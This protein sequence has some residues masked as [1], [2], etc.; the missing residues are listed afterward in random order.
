MKMHSNAERI[1]YQIYPK[2]FMDSNHDGIGDLNGIT[3]RLDYLQSLGVNTL[4]LNPIFV[5]PQVDN[6]YDVSNYFRIEPTLGTMADFEKLVTSVH[7]R[8]MELILDLVLNHTSDQHPWFKD[9]VSDPQSIYRNY[10]LWD[11]GRAG[12]VP[13]NWASFFGGSVWEKDPAGTDEYYFHLFDKAMPDLNWKNPEVR[14]AMV[15]IA[16][17]WLQRGVDGFRL[18]AFIHIAKADF[19][20]DVFTA[21]SQQP[22]IADEYYANLPQVQE[23]LAE[24]V[25][26]LKEIKADV[27]ILG[28]ASSADI[29]L[30]ESYTDPKRDLCDSVVSFRYFQD[31]PEPQL[32]DQLPAAGQPHKLDLAQ[33]KR[34]MV[35]WQAVLQ[36]WSLPTLYWSNHDLPRIL[37]KLQIEPSMQTDAAK[38]LAV[39]MYLQRGIPC[40]YYGEE[41]GMTAGQLTDPADFNDELA[42]SFVAT[43][44]SHGF[45]RESLLESLSVSHK[46]GARSVMQWTDGVFAGFSSQTPWLN[47][48]GNGNSVL[49]EKRD[50]DSVLNFYGQVLALRQKKLFT[51]GRIVFEVND[52]DL[53]GYTR[54]WEKQQAYIMCNLTDHEKKIKLTEEQCASR[55]KL[56]NRAQF[57]RTANKLTLGAYGVLVLE[58]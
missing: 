3:Q 56:K 34:T 30:V 25:H 4:W 26:A 44:T 58:G 37:D 41:L 35:S 18:D 42:E 47:A 17:F 14:Q 55:V 10:Y 45:V 33:F 43:G 50:P 5:S 27:F 48:K 12:Q 7:D 24:F 11:K 32:I 53:Y 16:K 57:D 20:Q 49:L 36:E 1:I 40:I 51:E 46:M 29:D 2:S 28:E 9:A 54:F 8:G 19:R 6:G 21:D 39:L 38:M 15:D 52:P 31:V 13:N 23:Y 22:Q